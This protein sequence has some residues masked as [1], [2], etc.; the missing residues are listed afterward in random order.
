VEDPSGIQ[1]ASEVAV[2]ILFVAFEKFLK[3]TW[4]NQMGPVISMQTLKAIQD[5][6]GE[7]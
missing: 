5:K 7:S 3:L 1:V 4:K 6:S 2:D